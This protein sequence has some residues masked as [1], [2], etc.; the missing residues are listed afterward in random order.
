MSTR[1]ATD[2]TRVT[3][4]A[5]DRWAEVAVP[6]DVP[7]AD[8]LPALVLHVGDE[9]LEGGPVVLQRL[10]G[11]PFTEDLT[12]AQLG[13]HDGDTVHLRPLEDQI[14]PVRFDDVVDGVA[15]NVRQQPGWSDSHLR[16][17]LLGLAALAGVTSG[18]LLVVS[19]RHD[20][21]PSSMVAVLGGLVA[22]GAARSMSRR[23]WGRPMARIL[24][25]SV[26]LP[27]AAYLA[28][29]FG[30]AAHQL[31]RVGVGL[32]VIV[33]ITAIAVRGCGPL[34]PAV[35]LTSLWIL[36]AGVLA[37]STPLGAVGAATVV[38]AA[39][40]LTGDLLAVV[41][42]WIAR[43]QVPALPAGPEGTG[44]GADR[45]DG[46][47]PGAEIVARAWRAQRYHAALSVSQGA[48][49]VTSGAVLAFAGGTAS[50]VLVGT[51]ALL[52][53][54]RAH[55][56][57]ALGPRLASVGVTVGLVA[58]AVFAHAWR[59]SAGT[60]ALTA[61][62][63]LPVAGALLV[64]CRWIPGRQPPASL[65]RAAD[66]TQSL[67]SLAIVPLSLAALGFYQ[68]LSALPHGR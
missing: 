64:A 44:P 23:D 57:Q 42:T 60:S 67:T 66:V 2:L 14:P 32:L 52:Q 40:T 22:L 7:L 29:L 28:V 26:V 15:A 48:V 11:A 12:L 5:P 10:G 1:A 37:G 31:A 9:R 68:L 63:L 62:A 43:I 13:V 24:V 3:V 49:L 59:G 61:L 21:E 16:Q 51:V 55:D 54:A 56:L 30:L 41:A 33:A 36:I 50:L 39:A 27:Y 4:V 58:V 35:G 18:L 47:L 19:A 65:A 17:V 46:P 6:S 34:L 45:A 25:A 38:L 8:L 20:L 53:L